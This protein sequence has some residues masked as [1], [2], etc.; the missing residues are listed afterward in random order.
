MAYIKGKSYFRDCER[1]KWLKVNFKSE[2]GVTGIDIAISVVVIFIF[3]SIIA[4]LSYNFN[5][6][7]KAVELESEATSIAIDEIEKMK[8]MDFEEIKDF[9]KTIE[10]NGEYQA[11]VE[12]PEKE[13]FYKKIILEDYADIDENKIP[14]LVKKATVEISYMFKGQEQKV[15]L[16][17]ILKK[18]V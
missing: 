10:N 1:G 9:R 8:N 16:A 17:T 7:T 6:K 3:V 18:D 2:K 14:G 11:L 15:Q 13:G 4:M 5:S 12:V